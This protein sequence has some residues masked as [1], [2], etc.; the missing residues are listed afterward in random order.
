MA[1]EVYEAL[2]RRA[3]KEGV[4][5]H[6]DGWDGHGMAGYF[7]P[8]DDEDLSPMIAI[9]RPYYIEIDE[10]SPHSNAPPPFAQ[11]DIEEELITLAHEYGHFCSFRGRT[12]RPEWDAYNAITRRRSLLEQNLREEAAD[13]LSDRDANDWYRAAL[14]ERLGEATCAA[15]MREEALAWQVGREVL[16]ELGVV[17]FTVYDER[18]RRGLHLHRY[19]LGLEDAWPDDDVATAE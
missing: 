4:W 18:R 7:A 2:W 13:G 5:V 8:R 12:P 3:E 9:T 15:I 16:A 10:P 19:R 11:P 14:G 6:Y 1:Y 17:D